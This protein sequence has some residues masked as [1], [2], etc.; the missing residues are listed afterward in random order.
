V[1]GFF[2]TGTDTGVGKTFVTCALAR[3][4]RTAGLRV[5]AFKPIETGVTGEWGE[6][7]RAIA[8]A[9]GD[10][11]RGTYRFELAAAPRVAAHAE[12]IEIDLARIVAEFQMG[13]GADRV[14]VEAAG[15]WRVPITTAHDTSELAR[16]IGLPVLVIARAGLGTINH[17]VLTVEAIARD[18]LQL[19]GIV[20]SVRP[21]DDRVFAASN[22]R[23]IA[24]ACG[25]TPWI[26]PDLP[27]F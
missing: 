20:L 24:A 15:G 23:E 22:A 7:Q 6:D 5:F 21:E 12:G 8:E 4:A 11:R 18:G 13:T 1:K 14:L 10:V 16:R 3:K 26:L 2:V 25:V 27:T 9:A 17:T 19:G